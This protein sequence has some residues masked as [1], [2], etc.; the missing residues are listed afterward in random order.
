MNFPGSPAVEIG[1]ISATG[2]ADDVEHLAA[3]V[4]LEVVGRLRVARDRRRYASERLPEAGVDDA[5]PR[6]P[7]HLLEGVDGVEQLAVESRAVRRGVV[8]RTELA[9]ELRD[10]AGCATEASRGSTTWARQ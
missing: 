10:G 6:E 1:T 4:H 3:L 7:L 2:R 8:Q 5:R 9:R